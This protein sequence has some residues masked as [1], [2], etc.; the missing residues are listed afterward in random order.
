MFYRPRF[1]SVT[2]GACAV[3]LLA[4]S[5]LFS[6]PAQAQSRQSAVTATT[7]RM[8][9]RAEAQVADFYQQYLDAVRQEHS[10]GHD[11]FTVRKEFLTPELD[12]ALTT[13]GSEH[14]V[15]PI[16]RREEFPTSWSLTD[17]GEADGHATVLLTQR[18][19]D[20]TADTNLLYQVRLDTLQID[21]LA[22]APAED[23][24]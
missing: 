19:A 12:D 10:E 2:I 16:L 14:Q 13:W 7:V 11:T 5:V 6:V 8:Q 23:P 17:K 15:D 3:A 4:G 1:R 9:T 20:G 21:G 24:A 18:W 22:D